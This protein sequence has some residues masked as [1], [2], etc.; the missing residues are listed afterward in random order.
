MSFVINDNQQISWNDSYS[1]LTSR[2]QKMLE[3]SWA[4]PF[5]EKLFPAINEEGFSVL[6]SNDKA[7][8]PNTP[9]NVIIGALILKEMM[10]QSDDD[11]LES[12]LFDVRYQVALRTTSFPEQ[13]MSDRS[14]GRFRTRCAAY[15]E[16]TGIDLIKD[17]IL[18][19]SK[20]IA[21]IMN[22]SPSLKRVDSLMVASNIKK[23]SRLELLYT[24]V[25]NMVKVYA[26]DDME[27]LPEKLKRYCEKD[28]RNTV[29]YHNRSDSTDER[30]AEVLEDAALILHLS[31][32]KYNESSEYH[33]LLRVL[34]EQTTKDE[35]GKYH[36]KDNSDGSMDSSILQNPSDPDATFRVKGGK[37]HQGYVANIIE[38]V[39]DTDSIITHYQYEP[40]NCPDTQ[41]LKEYLGGC[42]NSEEAE[43]MVADGSYSGE[44]LKEIA[45]SKNIDLV[46]TNMTGRKVADILGEFEFND[47][48]TKVIRC[49]GGHAPK[50]CSFVK[51]TSQCRVS[52]HRSVCESCPHKKECK[53]KFSKRTAVKVIS[54]KSKVR[55]LEQRY[56]KTEEFKGLAAIRNGIESIPSVLR[57]KYGVDEM[58]VRGKIRTKQLFGFKVAAI[59]FTKLCKYQQSLASSSLQ[60]STV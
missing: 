11:I 5:S 15:E 33:L 49:A 59:N 13:P 53:P 17:C 1:Q 7:S 40:N 23:L 48:G 14:L 29:I 10:N 6:Y 38:S 50:S 55:A 54:L 31:S 32:D 20:E 47:D 21:E 28:G 52:F 34:K 16:E 3:K 30:L 51:A 26:K 24:T 45:K 12:L 56:R 22:I 25:S 19:L 57:R 2:E 60:L 35:S 37:Q 18:S 42:P 41:L 27:S 44:E 8:R 39:N 43:T 58:P 46:T 9:V 4:I 36:L